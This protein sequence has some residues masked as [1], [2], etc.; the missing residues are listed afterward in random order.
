MVI[1]TADAVRCSPAWESASPCAR[2]CTGMRTR[3]TAASPAGSMTS[4]RPGKL[5]R[6]DESCM[7]CPFSSMGGF[8]GRPPARPPREDLFSVGEHHV[9]TGGARAGRAD[10]D[11]GV[12]VLVDDERERLGEVERRDDDLVG[13]LAGSVRVEIEPDLVSAGWRPRGV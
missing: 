5:R 3:V 11:V 13:G 2:K 7:F 8:S 1:A 6:F 4:G 10:A 9:A 12:R